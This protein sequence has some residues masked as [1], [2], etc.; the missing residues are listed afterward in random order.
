MTVI[1]N[2]YLTSLDFGVAN[3]LLSMLHIFF[4]YLNGSLEGPDEK[5]S[6]SL[7]K[8]HGLVVRVQSIRL[9]TFAE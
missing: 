5:F 9:T 2:V 6:P 8:C 1:P 3:V 4:E 7:L